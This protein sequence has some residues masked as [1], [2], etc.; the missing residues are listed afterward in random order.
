MFLM[1][2]L[3]LYF[4]LHVIE[5]NSKV[6]AKRY[7]KIANTLGLDGN[8]EDELTKSLVNLIKELNRELNIPATF[9]E[10][11]IDE[12][13]LLENLSF[14]S[15]NAVEDA[16]TATNPRKVTPEEIE[17]IYKASF[18]GEEVNF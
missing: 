9:K 11:G 4:F 15:K 1:D 5:F 2:V 7:A 18:Y 16:C 14:M 12:K 3:M 8:N 6:C 17:K 10:Y 13:E